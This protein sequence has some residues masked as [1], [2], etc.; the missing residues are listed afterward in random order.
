MIDVIGLGVTGLGVTDRPLLS[1]TA[2]L[3]L[4]N[5]VVVI[6]SKR[7]LQVVS[8]L[9]ANNQKQQ[10]VI[11][12]PLAKLA[13]L[14]DENKSV[15][16]VMLASGDP[17]HY[18]IGRWLVKTVGLD[19]LN[20]HPAVSSMQAACHL[21]GI[22]LQDVDVLSL[23]GRPLEKIRSVLKVKKNLLVLTDKN[24]QPQQLAQACLAAGFT[25]TSITVIEKIGYPEQNL[26]KFSLDELLNE[27]ALSFDP[28]HVSLIEPQGLGGCLPEFPGFEDQLFITG[29]EPGKGMIT[30]REVRLAILSLLQPSHSDVIWDIG[31]GCGSV[32]I[33]LAYWQKNA[34]IYALEHHDQRLTCLRN[35]REKFGVR[36][37]VTIVAGRAPEQLSSLPKA[38]K[39]FIG[40]SDGEL[41]TILQIAWQQ[42]PEH[43]LLVVS[44]VTENTKFQLQQFSQQLSHQQVETLQIAVS[45]GSHLAGQLMYKPNL[46]VTL[47]KFIK[48]GTE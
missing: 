48:H 3:A 30:K 27:N 2:Q 31:A 44:A 14:L 34:H 5:A 26:R 29:A 19:Q 1:N 24:S 40:G 22:S 41:Q 39:V 15:A 36:E 43:G 16:I 28:L 32:T 10:Q 17:L 11:L 13:Q 46:S 12:P 42:L 21:L 33:E 38:N 35:N 47:Y 37:N 8:Y 9:L 23:H 45:K 4:E 7:Q 20:F 6:G 18:G 25:Q